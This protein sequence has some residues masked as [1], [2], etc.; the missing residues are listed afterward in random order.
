MIKYFAIAILAGIV[1]AVAQVLLKKSSTIRRKR[2]I[3]EYLNRYVITGYSL[4]LG[5]MFLMILA[6]RS[7]PFKYGSVLDAL[8][9][10]YAMISGKIIF[11][12]K[13]TLKR[14]FGNI[15]IVVGIAVFSL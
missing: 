14:I 5:A 12:E 3:D 2:R 9:Y 1:S 10:I 7:M 6:F 8:S 13:I 4:M 11:G 15:L